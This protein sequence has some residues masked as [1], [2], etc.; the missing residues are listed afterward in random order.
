L[1]VPTQIETCLT[2]KTKVAERTT[3]VADKTL[4]VA[5]GTRKGEG[6]AIVFGLNSHIEKIAVVGLAAIFSIR[7]LAIRRIEK[8]ST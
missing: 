8:I 4:R 3:E 6:K 1:R 5:E 7:R 2:A